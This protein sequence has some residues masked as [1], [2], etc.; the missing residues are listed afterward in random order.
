MTEADPDQTW[1]MLGKGES[2]DEFECEKR[3]GCVLI[4]VIESKKVL[5]V[6][7]IH[8]FIFKRTSFKKRNRFRFSSGFRP[9][10]DLF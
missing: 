6:F 3:L 2:G 1:A 9:K 7:L 4:T 8:S 5:H 10:K